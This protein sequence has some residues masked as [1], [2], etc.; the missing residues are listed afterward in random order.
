MSCTCG[1]REGC[2][3]HGPQP[4]EHPVL[5]TMCY[6]RTTWAVD[7]ICNECHRLRERANA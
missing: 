3:E 6:L 5:C 7:G 2:A 1:S 4:R